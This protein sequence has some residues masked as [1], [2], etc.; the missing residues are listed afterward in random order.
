ME[1]RDVKDEY[2]AISFDTWKEE[3]VHDGSASLG[4]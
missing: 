1:Y 3:V 2:N 4:C